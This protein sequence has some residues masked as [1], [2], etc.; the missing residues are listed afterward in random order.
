M[1]WISGFVDLGLVN[2]GGGRLVVIVVSGNLFLC[3]LLWHSS[4]VGLL[5]MWVVFDAVWISV[6]GC[7]FICVLIC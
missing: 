4:C 6:F 1:L 7:W 5:L 2:C 3:G